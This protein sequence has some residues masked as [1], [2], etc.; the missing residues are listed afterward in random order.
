MPVEDH[1]RPLRLKGN[2]WSPVPEPELREWSPRLKASVVLPAYGAQEK[3]D[4]ALAALAAQDYPSDLTEVVVVDDHSDP[5][6]ALPE[7]RPDDTRLITSEAGGWG[8][9]HAMNA[10]IAA[11]T[12]DV[13][14]RLDSDMVPFRDHVSAHLWYHHHCDYLVVLGHKRFVAWDPERHGAAEVRDAV[15]AGEAAELFD[16]S[17]P[18]WIENYIGDHDRLRHTSSDLFRVFTGA[19]HSAR[20]DLLD[21]A[22]GYDADLKLGSDTEIGYRLIQAGAVFVPDSASSSWHL[23]LGQMKTDGDAGRVQRLPYLTQRIPLYRHRRVSPSRVWRVPLVDVR[24][25]FPEGTT[26]DQ[27]DDLVAPLLGGS[28]GDIRVTVVNPAP[29]EAG[30]RGKVLGA[31]GSH[32]PLVEELYSGEPR[33]VLAAEPADDPAVPFTLHW[34]RGK[35]AKDT[36][37]TLVDRMERDRLGVLDALGAAEATMVRTAARSRA[38]LVGAED[39]HAALGELWGSGSIDLREP[40]DEATVYRP[41]V[42]GENSGVRRLARNMLSAGQRQR[43]KRLLGR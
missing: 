20:K 32:W 41:H 39:E 42:R 33:V 9:G 21:R 35:A 10:G 16:E 24:V 3:L 38:R 4:L 25:D 30:S 1:A 34:R 43:I 19:T 22:G 11:A 2:D 40:A 36:V 12:G 23:G 5:P 37:K 26:V 31:D 8:S 6:L 27:L 15:A 13:V 17:Q 18:H 14:V 7:V 29:Q 28:V